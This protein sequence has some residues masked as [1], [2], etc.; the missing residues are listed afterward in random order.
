MKTIDIKGKEYVPVTER[1]LYFNK[2]YPEWRIIT[3]IVKLEDGFVL[4]KAS[5]LDAD[6]KVLATAHAYEKESSSFINKTSFI[7][8]CETSA[9]GRVLGILGIGIDTSLAS[10]EEVANAVK[11]QDQPKPPRK[12]PE[13][14]VIILREY[15]ESAGRDESEILKFYKIDNLNQLTRTNCR[16]LIDRLKEQGGNQ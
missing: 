14:D 11:N 4:M 3:E 13:E 15:L 10:Y 6:G 9:I 7:E 1:I 16:R 12:L 5:V 8:N 2:H